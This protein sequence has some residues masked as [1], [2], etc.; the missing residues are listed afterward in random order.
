MRA[1][2]NDAV[3]EAGAEALVDSARR[4]TDT[5]PANARGDPSA[6]ATPSGQRTPEL[7]QSARR[8][9][10]PTIAASAEH[11]SLVSQ[12]TLSLR[13]IQSLAEQRSALDRT[14]AQHRELMQEVTVLQGLL[15]QNAAALGDLD[16]EHAR[17]H[18]TRLTERLMA[19]ARLPGLKSFPQSRYTLLRSAARIDA[20]RRTADRGADPSRPERSAST[21]SNPVLAQSFARLL[22]RDYVRP[23]LSAATPAER[24]AHLEALES[25]FSAYHSD[26]SQDAA[27]QDHSV[28]PLIDVLVALHESEGIDFFVEASKVCSA[29]ELGLLHALVLNIPERISAIRF[30][31]ALEGASSIADTTAFFPDPRTYDAFNREVR[32]LTGYEATELLLRQSLTMRE[33]EGRVQDERLREHEWT[34]IQALYSSDARTQ[35]YRNNSSAE[36][37]RIARER[38]QAVTRADDERRLLTAAEHIRAAATDRGIVSGVQAL[39]GEL[40]T[41]SI[42]VRGF[43]PS[44]QRLL[45][46]VRELET[47]IALDRARLGFDQSPEFSVRCHHQLTALG[48]EGDEIAAKVGADLRAYVENIPEGFLRQRFLELLSTELNNRDQSVEDVLAAAEAQFGSLV[49]RLGDVTLQRTSQE[50]L[51]QLATLQGQPEGTIILSVGRIFDELPPVA[52]QALRDHAD[53][54]GASLEERL[55]ALGGPSLVEFAAAVERGNE[56]LRDALVA[57]SLLRSGQHD[58]AC[59]LI[60]ASTPEQLAHLLSIMRERLGGTAD[61]SVSVLLTRAGIAASRAA[62]IEA[63]SQAEGPE[64]AAL[65]LEASLG[66]HGGPLALLELNRQLAAMSPEERAN[67]R[68]RLAPNGSE[69]LATRLVEEGGVDHALASL[70]AELLIQGPQDEAHLVTALQYYAAALERTT[71]AE[72]GL[73]DIDRRLDQNEAYRRGALANADELRRTISEQDLLVG[74]WSWVTG[75]TSAV[76]R[77]IENHNQLS[78]E[79]GAQRTVMLGAQSDAR[80]SAEAARAAELAVLHALAFNRQ[81]AALDA[82]QRAQVS[83]QQFADVMNSGRT[84]P[85]PD[86]TRYNQETAQF[87]NSLDSSIRALDNW[88]TGLKVTRTVVIFVGGAAV[89]VATGGAALPAW[90]AALLVTAAAAP[91]TAV[92]GVLDV[93]YGNK[94][95]GEAVQD[96]V[97][98]TGM[99]FLNAWGAGSLSRGLFSSKVTVLGGGEAV[100]QGA[101]QVGRTYSMREISRIVGVRVSTLWSRTPEGLRVG[102][103]LTE[104]GLLN[105]QAVRSFWELG[106]AAGGLIDLARRYQDPAVQRML[107]RGAV[108]EEERPLREQ[109]TGSRNERI[110]ISPID[111]ASTEER[112]RLSFQQK[113]ALGLSPE[114]LRV[115]LTR[116][117]KLLIDRELLRLIDPFL[118]DEMYGQPSTTPSSDTATTDLSFLRVSPDNTP[119]DAPGASGAGSVNSGPES[120]PADP[121]MS[122]DEETPSNGPDPLTLL[123]RMFGLGGARNEREDLQTV[124]VVQAP[125][126][127]SQEAPDAK[128]SDEPSASSSDQTNSAPPGTGLMPTLQNTGNSYTA[129]V[130]N[131]RQVV[132]GQA[133]PSINVNNAESARAELQREAALQ[134]R[135]LELERIR[136][137]E[138]QARIAQEEAVRRVELN[139]KWLEELQAMASQQLMA[140]LAKNANSKKTQSAIPN[141]MVTT[142]A[143]AQMVSDAAGTLSESIGAEQRLSRDHARREQLGLNSGIGF[144]AE[145]LEAKRAAPTLGSAE[146]MKSAAP[147][148]SSDA[149]RELVREAQREA[150]RPAIDANLEQQSA[151][152]S[153]PQR[154]Q[155]RAGTNH[156]AAE[157]MV[158]AR[159][160]PTSEQI[161]RPILGAR[162]QMHGQSNPAYRLQ[163]IASAQLLSDPVL[164]Q[165]LMS[166]FSGS[167]SLAEVLLPGVQRA[168][169]QLVAASK[170]DSQRAERTALP[171]EVRIAQQVL[172]EVVKQTVK[173]SELGLDNSAT[174]MNGSFGTRV[175]QASYS[176]GGSQAVLA[177]EFRG[178][179]QTSSP[180][181]ASH[182]TRAQYTSGLTPGASEGSPMTASQNLSE[183]ISPIAP[184]L[185]S[186][187][188]R[189]DEQPLYGQAIWTDE[190]E[191]IEKADALRRLQRKKRLKRHRLKKHAIMKAK[192]LLEELQAEAERQIALGAEG[193]QGAVEQKLLKRVRRSVARAEAA[194][195]P[196]QEGPSKETSAPESARNVVR[197]VD[198]QGRAATRRASVRRLPGARRRMGSAAGEI[199]PP[200]KNSRVSTRANRY[201]TLKLQK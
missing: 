168:T 111:I 41:E 201:R 77:D 85:L 188:R 177:T 106:G 50:V 156:R 74:G 198:Q 191:D 163:A 36:V 68:D 190:L 167:Q 137:L 170:N 159:N 3:V 104:K 4:S 69:A 99:D 200:S 119:D 193:A 140:A 184:H 40:A 89:V 189:Q 95:T 103:M 94:T 49:Q 146:L 172:E 112:R 130:A 174:A 31:R 10:A 71:L 8:E 25:I 105:V 153:E 16:E 87:R 79:Y 129:A 6:L 151:Q 57:L 62:F 61:D 141:G 59:S 13:R 64:R 27:V 131:Q 42:E 108:P 194:K 56:P 164:T 178:A 169:T 60:L 1:R 58:A 125:V 53:Q 101:L 83:W 81:Q 75:V 161:G 38:E 33:G 30:V 7:L 121:G 90:K 55:H 145:A 12:I 97:V 185:M 44:H 187:A 183:S 9:V 166:N 182:V 115:L 67:I 84:S 92:Q 123:L 32:S 39:L 171:I 116:E 136:F 91:G 28:P 14:V 37:S 2:A 132:D 134:A 175:S 120:P 150:G 133:K 82:A 199:T 149:T 197:S 78:L 143:G 98:Q 124:P 138:R 17:Q 19:A 179:A 118:Y 114:E 11:Q 192:A 20:Q 110:Q 18:G 152:I 165:R 144:A 155:A 100:G 126:P 139:R 181:V 107:G 26:Q 162:D 127:S 122:G 128:A 70:A 65:M 51:R 157:Q 186:D 142:H 86:Y 195:V 80:R 147:F 76:E 148:G 109:S 154:A 45:L 24:T 52:L 72:E 93:N 35:M 117:E 66:L 158:M 196:Q 34:I 29:E 54:E 135:E 23:L 180:Q 22:G 46:S 43:D 48:T 96:S 47:Q 73:H 176:S 173:A 21:P 88:E 15:D 113:M 160:E 102:A 5:L 63:L